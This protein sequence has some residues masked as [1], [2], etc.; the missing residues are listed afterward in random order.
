M[1]FSQGSYLLADRHHDG[2]PAIGL[3]GSRLEAE[4]INMLGDELVGIVEEAGLDPDYADRTQLRQA[5]KLIARKIA[6]SYYPTRQAAEDA[7]TSDEVTYGD[8]GRVGG[9]AAEGDGG[10]FE[11]EFDATESNINP[12]QGRLKPI[13]TRINTKWFG[14][15]RNATLAE[16]KAALQ[17]AIAFA[18]ANG[19]GTVIVDADARYGLSRYNVTTGPDFKGVTNSIWVEDRSDAAS[20]NTPSRDGA[21]SRRWMYT[22]D[23][24]ND[25]LH[26]GNTDWWRANHHP[27]I[28]L[29]NDR[30]LPP[31]NDAARSISD[32]RNATVFFGRQGV[33]D[34]GIGMGGNSGA[35]TSDNELSGF[36]LI[37]NNLGTGVGL[38]NVL[39][40]S[41]T[42]ANTS[43]HTT[44][45]TD[46]YTMYMR[47]ETSAKNF[48]LKAPNANPQIVLE[49]DPLDAEGTPLL[50]GNGN[51]VTSD[52][53]TLGRSADNFVV[54]MDGTQVL[55]VGLTGDIIA[56]DATAALGGFTYE[57]DKPNGYAA[58]I[59]N[60][61]NAVGSTAFSAR[62]LNANGTQ[63]LIYAVSARQLKFQVKS[64]GA[65]LA[66]GNS[67]GGLSDE[68]LKKDII[69][70]RSQWDDI[71]ALRVCNYSMKADLEG[72]KHLGVIAQELQKTSP[73]LVSETILENDETVL[74]VNY[75]ILYLK[76]VKALQEAM[77]RIEKLEERILDTAQRK[78]NM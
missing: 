39:N 40:I 73:S 77:S 51:P 35:G 49:K 55:K 17:A 43:W 16:N 54:S 12:G 42:T 10:G 29:M 22:P 45:T 59:S 74:S 48:R 20:Y 4:F 19:G 8:K 38:T 21:Q 2:N 41:K 68:R 56:G 58:V 24:L 60:E 57:A 76:A 25:H 75:S 27:A 7:L 34:W 33:V 65:V 15:S 37:A 53:L 5:V 62:C 9:Y 26:D 36:K 67:Y 52:V 78:G 64:N 11:F 28:V 32:N 1:D 61:S 47:E 50:D 72:Q 18:D 46:A 70:A 71:K 44:Q 14:A 3:R 66:D 63:N 13:G 31:A 23:P 30:I 6:G 69:D